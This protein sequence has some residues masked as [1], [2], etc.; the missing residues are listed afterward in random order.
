MFLPQMSRP[1]RQLQ[2]LARSYGVETGYR[3]VG[4]KRHEA[5]EQALVA[6]LHA[7]GAAIETPDQA[8]AALR[9]R[10]QQ[11]W[12]RSLEPVVV[13]WEG[14]NIE[15]EIRLPT[16]LEGAAVRATI[17]LESGEKQ[18]WSTRLRRL[19]VLRTIS[20]SGVPYAARRL[21]VPKPLPTGYHRLTLDAGA[22]RF[23]SLLLC[24]PVQAYVP[25]RGGEAR[26][27]GLFAPLYAIHSASSWGSG[28]FTD[29][30][31]F[32]VW[33][34]AQGADAVATLPILAAFLDEPFDPSPY[35]PASRLFWNELYLD[36]TRIPELQGCEAAQRII[37]SPDHQDRVAAL[38]SAPLV[39]YRGVASVKRRVLAELARSF[40]AK[41]SPRQ[42][43]LRRFVR[44]HPYAED[45]A[46]FRAVGEQRQAPWPQ[47]SG[48]VRNGIVTEAD[49]REEAKNYHLYVQW[50]A[51]E[52][53]ASLA[54]PG[55]SRR[56]MLYLDLPLGV[57]PDGYDV[58][59]ER[60]L[61]ASRVSGGAPPDAVF[62]KGQNWGFP[63][64]HP[65]N[66]REQGYGYYIAC[67]RHHM[68][69]AGALRIDHVMNL[70]RLYWIPE[71]LEASEGVYVRYRPDEFYAVLSLE[72]HGN[73]S[74]VV[75]EDLG[76]VPRGVHASMDRHRVLRMYVAQYEAK[77]GRDSPLPPVPRGCV[78]S[79]NT[80]DMPPFAAFLEGLD[81]DDFLEL[82]LIDARGLRT[83]RRNRAALQRAIVRFLI[84]QR[85]T[86]R[87]GRARNA[88]RAPLSVARMCELCR[89]VLLHLAA[90]PAQ[91]LLV[92]LEDLWLE[93]KPQNVPGTSQDRPNWRRKA[94]YGL[95]EFTRRPK[96][97]ETLR[98][99][100]EVR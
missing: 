35:S 66:M 21:A 1:S 92:N 6:V 78:A 65:E 50:L 29:L 89:G 14:E 87:D 90:S 41:P 8:H 2:E 5:S 4:G 77:T 53:L 93:T 75:G 99:I 74:F 60:E 37:A 63:P 16:R 27:T 69:F 49:Y 55:G 62:T 68:K 91:L 26:M 3:D 47:W 12:Q 56:P 10:R 67:L 96:V 51:E 79:L 83:G 98:A 97:I 31:R 15:A 72:S 85:L 100:L 58:W 39:D 81:L 57:H 94:R 25:D 38:R 34:A 42:G 24:A 22:Q 36:V 9:A 40:F 54:P 28:D 44:N 7:L 59:R 80:H 86:N 76:T 82:G 23:D 88:A 32:M 52:Q 18:S 17:E 70:N 73:R 46:R 43:A 11:L 20:I 45:Y 95:E 71:G 48:P 64:P 19:P 30:R 13:A 84:A 61:F 33:A